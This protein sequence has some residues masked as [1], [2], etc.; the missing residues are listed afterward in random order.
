[1][2]FPVVN[3]SLR[4]MFQILVLFFIIFIFIS[5]RERLTVNVKF[6]NLVIFL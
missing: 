4:P 1:V 5:N 3:D 2:I 6:I